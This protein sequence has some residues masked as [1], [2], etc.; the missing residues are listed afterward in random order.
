ML[1]GGCLMNS[2]KPENN[3]GLNKSVYLGREF[4]G[5]LGD[6]GTFLPHVL[7]SITVAGLSPAGVFTWFGIFYLFSGWFYSIPMA[8]QPMK[9]ASAAILVQKLSPGEVAAAGLILG[10]V[11]LILGFSG[12]IE[13]LAVITPPGVTGGIQVGL[14]L[15]LAILGI[16]MLGADP[17][18]GWLTVLLMLPLLASRRL[19]SALIVLLA[20]TF[21]GFLLNPGLSWP[22]LSWGWH[23]PEL[24]LPSIG[25][26]KKALFLVALP[27]IPLTLTNAVLVTVAI[28]AEL[29]GPRAKR[30]TE[31][32]LSLTM[33]FA[34]LVTAPLGG[35]MMCHGSG[36]VAAHHRFGGRTRLTPFI[37]GLFLV[38]V[39]I[40]LG[41]D[42]LKV[43]HLIPE[44]VLGSLLFYSGLD[45]AL[46]VRS[47]SN[48]QELFL[49]LLVTTLTLALNPAIAFLG[50]LLV[51]K[52]IKMKLIN[53]P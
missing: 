3:K 26:F 35:Y 49:I 51:S 45:L 44:G 25:D 8:V 27:Q 42:A 31:R 19:P 34:N 32:N 47:I 28:S 40:L 5:A 52:A 53:Y 33:G 7:A 36:G 50:G 12:L 13:K 20:G 16:K 9:A 38:S 29:Y 6:L 37:I 4:S 14:G 41:P 1:L 48:R 43:L 21:L 30:V 46:A 17:V 10:I 11:L 24:I 23:M 22:Q 18:I 39:G 15:S 2:S